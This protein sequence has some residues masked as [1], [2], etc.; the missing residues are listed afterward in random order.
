MTIITDHGYIPLTNLFLLLLCSWYIYFDVQ[1]VHIGYKEELLFAFCAF[2]Q[3]YT[4]IRYNHFFRTFSENG[5]LKQ[6]NKI[7]N[8]RNEY[9]LVRCIQLTW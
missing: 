1:P 8:Q 4:C 6:M 5:E 3:S 7:Q 2:S 9:D